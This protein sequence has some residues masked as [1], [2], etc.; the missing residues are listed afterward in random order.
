MLGGPSGLPSGGSNQARLKRP[1]LLGHGGKPARQRHAMDLL[2][3]DLAGRRLHGRDWRQAFFMPVFYLLLQG[4]PQQRGEQKRRGDR[5]S[6]GDAG[7]G[8]GKGA[9][10]KTQGEI[11]LFPGQQGFGGGEQLPE[12]AVLAKQP[13][14][15]QGMTTVEEFEGFIE[16]AGRRDF[17][18]KV[19]EFP[20]GGLGIRVEPEIEL[21]GEPDRAQ[22][23]HGIFP[24]AHM[25]IAD[26]AE[27]TR[28]EIRHAAGKIDDGKVGDVVVQ[29]V[30]G[31]IPA[32][33]VLGNGGA[34]YVV[35]HDPV[36]HGE[37]IP[38][39]GLIPMAAKRRHLNDLA[40]EA[41]VRQ[42]KPASDEDAS[43]FEDLPHLIREGVGND[44]EILRLSSQEQ[45][46]DAPPHQVSLETGLF[47]LVEYL[48]GIFADVRAGNAMPGPGYDARRRPCS[49]EFGDVGRSL[50]WFF[51]CAARAYPGLCVN[52]AAA[53]VF[54]RSPRRVGRNL[55]RIQ[56]VKKSDPVSVDQSAF[57]P[58]PRG[59][60]PGGVGLDSG[61][62][63]FQGLCFFD[64]LNYRTRPH[65][66]QSV[67]EQGNRIITH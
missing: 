53:L 45:I 17:L 3:N 62:Q 61:H 36:I 65:G 28:F 7:V 32:P 25:G 60:E 66:A 4:R 38:S 19:S 59:N 2:F 9:L 27:R 23:A 44:V 26:E 13:E 31:E 55:Y 41:H 30:Y 16:Q 42:T 52:P 29:A 37:A 24:A 48:K 49:M 58:A 34:V 5:F 1:D 47:Q 14:G 11:G 50:G 6:L 54:I 46:A 67:L 10:D 21:G 63:L 51:P 56:S 8:V 64:T 22:D 40:A 20:D 12:K 18:E 35:P 33:D 39:P 43:P 15:R 57:L